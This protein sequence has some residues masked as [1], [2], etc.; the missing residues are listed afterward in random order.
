MRKL[1]D[2]ERAQKDWQERT[3]R[4]K[5]FDRR[6][7]M[8]Q[9]NASSTIDISK[10]KLSFS[11]FERQLLGDHD[12]REL[13][14]WHRETVDYRHIPKP[15]FIRRRSDKVVT[16]VKSALLSTAVRYRTQSNGAQEREDD[17]HEQDMDVE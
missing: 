2:E 9:L 3:I 1:Q 6:R 8:A 15:G 4:Q 7:R 14:R 13:L 5:Q 17:D 12:W 10:H 11:L 16:D